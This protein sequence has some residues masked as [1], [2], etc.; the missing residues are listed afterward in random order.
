MYS[1]SGHVSVTYKQI[2]YPN[3]KKTVIYSLFCLVTATGFA[4]DKI[5]SSAD[6]SPEIYQVG[7]KYPGYIIQESGDTVKGFL[8]AKMR[9]A[10]AGIGNSNQNLAEFFL[11]ENDKKATAKYKPEDIKGYMIADKVYESIAYSSV[12]NYQVEVCFFKHST[13]ISNRFVYFICDHIT[14]DV[15]R[16]VFCCRFFV[17]FVQVEFS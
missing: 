1:Q 10:I 11:N 9:C 5:Q 2:K 8:E 4:Q 16:F 12:S 14:F 3:M 15:L 6:W 17:V 7:K 13:A